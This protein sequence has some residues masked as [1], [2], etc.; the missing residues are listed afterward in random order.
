MLFLSFTSCRIWQAKQKLPG[1]INDEAQFCRHVH[2]QSVRSIY[3]FLYTFVFPLLTIFEGQW[4]VFPTTHWQAQFL[5]LPNKKSNKAFRSLPLLLL[6]C[7]LRNQNTIC[8]Q[9]Y[10]S[11]I[12]GLLK[13]LH[14]DNKNWWTRILPQVW[15]QTVK[16]ALSSILL[17]QW[18]LDL[19]KSL[20]TGQIC[21]LNRGFVI[22][23]TSIYRIWGVIVND[24]FA[25][26]VT[27]VEI[28]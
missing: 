18:N 4:I 8:K 28:L 23:K 20:G 3:Q 19:T 17:L 5:S 11:W 6:P 21:S 7:D 9:W 1:Y 12:T 10:F 14:T 27:S 2:E 22:S 24:W 26:Q 25:T 15:M 16:I 13:R